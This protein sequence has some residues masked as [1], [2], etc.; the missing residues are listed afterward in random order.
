MKNVTDSFS[1]NP[2]CM[3]EGS[4]GSHFM[5]ISVTNGLINER[6]WGGYADRIACHRT[7]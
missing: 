1:F 7:R 2:W 4:N 3:Q 6:E 5:S